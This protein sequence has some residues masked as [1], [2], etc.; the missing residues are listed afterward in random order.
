MLAPSLMPE[1]VSANA[2]VCDAFWIRKLIP[3]AWFKASLFYREFILKFHLLLSTS[4]EL[5]KCLEI[6]VG[7]KPT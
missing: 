6:K 1:Y 7:A 4:F 5:A 2:L 3:D